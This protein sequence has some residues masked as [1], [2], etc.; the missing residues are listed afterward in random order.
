M[1]QV[2]DY[3]IGERVA[4]HPSLDLWMMGIRYGDVKALGVDMVVVHIDHLNRD[5]R[6]PPHLIKPV[7]AKWEE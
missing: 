5:V 3:T 2:S 1:R 6:I 7:A 4:L